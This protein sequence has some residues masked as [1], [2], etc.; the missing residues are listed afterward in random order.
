MDHSFVHTIL[1]YWSV[2]I[3][4]CGYTCLYFSRVAAV[5]WSM[6]LRWVTISNDELQCFSMEKDRMT[7][8]TLFGWILRLW[9]F[10]P[11]VPEVLFMPISSSW[12]AY[13]FIPTRLWICFCQ[14]GRSDHFYCN[15]RL[16]IDMVERPPG[17]S[18]DPWPEKHGL[19]TYTVD[20][21]SMAPQ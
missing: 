2:N 7:T 8:F 9:L 3:S 19:C 15:P 12:W 11:A 6:L 16:L 13:L 10:F 14:L 1:D 17:W 18:C 21:E 20:W 5:K 4:C